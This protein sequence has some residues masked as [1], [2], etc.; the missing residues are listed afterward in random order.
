MIAM[1]K[2][3]HGMVGIDTIKLFTLADTARTRGHNLNV[4]KEHATRLARRNA[5]FQR[6]ANDGNTLP[7]HVV[8]AQ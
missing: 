2:I 1:Y 4:F 7:Q 8:R 3:L 5:F 6:V